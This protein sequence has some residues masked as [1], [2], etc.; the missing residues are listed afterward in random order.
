[1]AWLG[2]L[3]VQCDDHGIGHAVHEAA[4]QL[5]P[6]AFVTLILERQVRVHLPEPGVLNGECEHLPRPKA[7]PGQYDLIARS[8]SSCRPA[9]SSVVA[10]GFTSWTGF[11]LVTEGS[12]SHT[13]SEVS[14]APAI[15]VT[16]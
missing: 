15:W 7:V 11:R 14:P 16:G 13:A 1:M 2:A 12:R 3:D 9:G 10:P 8:S 6:E 5:L 4:Q